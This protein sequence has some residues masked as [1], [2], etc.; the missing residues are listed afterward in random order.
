MLAEGSL[1]LTSVRLLAPHLNEDNHAELLAAASG[2][3]RRELEELL[4]RRFPQPEVAS[5]IRKLPCPRPSLDP[6]AMLATTRDP[7]AGPPAA[8]ATPAAPADEDGGGTTRSPVPPAPVP[9]S[10]FRPRPLVTPLAP[11]RYQITFT[12][13]A[14]TREKLQL[15]QDLLRHT[16]PSGDPA[17]IVDRALTALLRDLVREKVAAIEQPRSRRG[18][19]NPPRGSRHIPVEVK[20]AVWVRD[21][22]RCA[23]VGRNGRRCSERGFVEF[24]HVQ[25]YAAGGPATAENIQLRCQAHNAYEADLY[26]RPGSTPHGNATRPEPSCVAATQPHTDGESR[27]GCR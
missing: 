22:G 25:P 7:A 13:G 16:I 1:N 21:L 5:S 4:A 6:S 20:R 27:P 3:S 19:A 26:Y 18:P 24:H 10:P 2:R 11:D 15:A 12:V 9:S 14:E 8:A 23:F 17:A